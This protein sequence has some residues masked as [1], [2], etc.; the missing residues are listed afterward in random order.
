MANSL[1]R[2]HVTSRCIVL[3]I[4]LAA[5]AL[6][7]RAGATE[8]EKQQTPAVSRAQF[9]TRIADR[10]PTD[11]IERLSDDRTRILFYSELRGLAGATISHRW[12]RDGQAMAEVPF[13][14]KANRWRVWSSKNL[15]PSWLG[16]WTVSVVTQDGT[17]LA[18]RSFTYHEK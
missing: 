6:A 9:T 4:S 7:S 12:E 13:L 15:E 5:I 8:P 14:V 17:I 3:I 16:T 2:I 10:E 11:S 1:S 18:S